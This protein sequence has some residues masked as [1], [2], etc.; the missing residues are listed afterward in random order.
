LHTSNNGLL[1]HDSYE[2]IQLAKNL[3]TKQIFSRQPLEPFYPEHIRVPGYPLFILLLKQNYLAIVIAQ[4][5]LNT[6]SVAIS[7]LLLKQLNASKYNLIIAGVLLIINPASFILSTTVITESIS[8]F[9]LI[10]AIIILCKQITKS[11][12]ILSGILLGYLIFIKPL[13]YFLPLLIMLLVTIKQKNLKPLL[14]LIFPAI[15]IIA[16]S[17]RNYRHF[18]KFFYSNIYIQNLAFYRAGEIKAKTNNISLEEAQ[19]IIRKE[20]QQLTAPRFN[21][22]YEHD[23]PLF[24]EQLQQYSLQLIKKHPLV[25]IKSSIINS[26]ILVFNPPI[27]YLHNQLKQAPIKP[28]Q[29]QFISFSTKM[30]FH[31]QQYSPLE[32]LI[33][34]CSLTISV[35]IFLGIVYSLIILAKWNKYAINKQIIAITIIY[36]FLLSI[37]PEGDMRLRYMLDFQAIILGVNFI[38]NKLLYDNIKKESC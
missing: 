4:I 20:V 11:T 1:I 26:F 10:L 22:C 38:L 25:Y 19:N 24:Y 35:L 21:Y 27:N 17:Y 7:L 30:F 23:T 16:W 2:Y 8:V 33:L 12:L 32:F 18:N 36:V 9:T 28:N 5:I 29:N 14:L 37:G 6:L 31:L 3:I 13:F 34:F 15:L